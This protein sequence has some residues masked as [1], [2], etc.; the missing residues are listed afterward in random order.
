M[1]Y[2]FVSDDAERGLMAERPVVAEKYW[3]WDGTVMT[4]GYQA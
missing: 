2:E 1:N 4:R 3:H